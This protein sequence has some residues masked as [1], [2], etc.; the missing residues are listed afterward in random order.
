M[1]ELNNALNDNDL[2]KAV[3]GAFN[4]ND[5]GDLTWVCP[6]CGTVNNLFAEVCSGCNTTSKDMVV[7]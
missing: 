7:G 1:N 4:K 6:D 5:A 3:G 2:E